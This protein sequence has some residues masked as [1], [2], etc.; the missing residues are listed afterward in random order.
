MFAL[1]L[2]LILLLLFTASVT[3]GQTASHRQRNKVRP[4]H[5]HSSSRTRSSE[6]IRLTQKLRAHGATV[7]LT[8]EKV[9]QP[10]FSMAGRI[11]NINGEPVQAFEYA[12]SSAADAEARRVSADGNTIGTTKPTWMASPHFF[13]SGK[14]VVLYVG[15][16][17]SIVDLLRTVLGAQFAGG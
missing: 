7:A 12:T 16:N 9:R 11:I 4:V 2:K 3:F 13:K 14:L 6:L 1:V 17:Q 15:G 5:T 10:F 8:K